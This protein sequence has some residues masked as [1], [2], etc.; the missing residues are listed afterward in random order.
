MIDYDQLSSTLRNFGEG[1]HRINKKEF[2]QDW[3]NR[4]ITKKE[5]LKK[6]NLKNIHAVDKFAAECNL[7]SR[8]SFK[9]RL[10]QNKDEEIKKILNHVYNF[11]DI[12]ISISKIEES[13]VGSRKKIIE[14]IN[15]GY[16]VLDDSTVNNEK[17]IFLNPKLKPRF[18][19]V[20]L[21]KLKQM[22]LNHDVTT[23]AISNRLG[24]DDISAVSRIANCIGLPI[25]DRPDNEQFT[26]KKNKFKKLWNDPSYTNKQIAQMLQV[27]V[28]TLGL[29]RKKLRLLP[30]EFRMQ[31]QIGQTFEDFL[32]KMLEKN[33]GAISL[34][35]YQQKTNSIKSREKYTS[36]LYTTCHESEHLSIFRLPMWLIS[37]EFKI[38]TNDGELINNEWYKTKRNSRPSKLSMLISDAFTL[39]DNTDFSKS[40][41]FFQE[42]ENQCYATEGVNSE[43]PKLISK[44]QIIYFSKDYD[45]LLLKIAQIFSDVTAINEKELYDA[46]SEFNIY[47]NSRGA[48]D[49]T[50]EII[51][52]KI[53]ILK[54][55]I[56]DKEK[57]KLFQ[58]GIK[59]NFGNKD[60]R[61]KFDENS[62]I[63]NSFSN[64]ASNI[65]E[66]SLKE[67]LSQIK[68]F[69]AISHDDVDLL[70][71]LK[72]FV[73]VT[74]NQKV[75]I[76]LSRFEIYFEKICKNVNYPMGPRDFLRKKFNCVCYDDKDIDFLCPHCHFI[77]WNFYRENQDP[78]NR[79]YVSN[80]I[81]NLDF[82]IRYM[83]PLEDII[84]EQISFSNKNSEHYEVISLLL[85]G[86]TIPSEHGFSTEHGNL[87]AAKKYDQKFDFQK[88]YDKYSDFWKLISNLD[89]KKKN[90]LLSF[91]K[92]QQSSTQKPKK[93][94]KYI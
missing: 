57:L 28:P 2:Q 31:R 55:I 72:E 51:L 66:F 5:L 56:N 11:N 49:A 33:H 64:L 26:E 53:P 6:Y 78:I 63:H 81:Q 50:R 62:S 42:I 20:D 18:F 67:T 54:E 68:H 93:E 30:R 84:F 41:S 69:E 40:I 24:L 47:D 13:G 73:F 12:G 15:S 79:E 14:I 74:N 70:N 17:V 45:S 1:K 46:L 32:I 58:D 82:I 23:Q 8:Y 19:S 52:K 65:S 59:L 43:T 34:Y 71:H 16:L 60:K 39:F 91:F 87:L 83:C 77:L 92:S 90:I 10:E 86:K 21:R 22:Y 35:D 9:D 89:D 37:K 4:S 29:W 80:F 27:S 25:R 7:D 75:S 38:S 88:I 76:E 85:E 44:F 3:K 48:A 61:E 94:K 36:R